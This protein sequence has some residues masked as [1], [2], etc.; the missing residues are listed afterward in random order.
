[1]SVKLNFRKKCVLIK[2]YIKIYFNLIIGFK[3]KNISLASDISYLIFCH[4]YSAGIQDKSARKCSL[5]ITSSLDSICV[6]TL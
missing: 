6:K 3:F 1:M 2:V 5:D 4:T